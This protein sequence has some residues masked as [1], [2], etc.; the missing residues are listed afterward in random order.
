MAGTFCIYEQAFNEQF[1]RILETTGC[2]T[3]TELAIFLGIQQSRVSDAVRRKKIPDNWLVILFENKR[4]N[5]EWIRTGFGCK[6]LRNLNNALERPFLVISAMEHCVVKNYASSS[7][8]TNFL[9]RTMR[10]AR[11]K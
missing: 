8:F 6:F 7:M 3:K 4:I 10:I 9:R 5:P 11:I 1:S 2:N